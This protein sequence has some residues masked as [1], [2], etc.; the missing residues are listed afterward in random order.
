MTTYLKI[1]NPGVCPIE[2]FTLLG[3]TS[4]TG[5]N[6]AYCIGQFGSGTKLS[7]GV[8]IRAKLPPVVFCSKHKL[9]FST[10]R[11]V[12]KALEGNTHYDRIV[13]K[14]GGTDEHGTSVTYTEELSQ[15]ESYGVLDWDDIGM[16][17]REF[18]SNAIDATIKFNEINSIE[19]KYPFDGVKVEIVDESQVR[20]KQGFTRVFV[21]MTAEEMGDGIEAAVVNFKNNLGKWFLHFSEPELIGQAI[22]PKRNRNIKVDCRTAV[23][24]RRGVRVREINRQQGESLFDYN[25][26]KL[27]MD[28]SRNVDDYVAQGEASKA[29]AS[30]DKV[31][32]A[33]WF[34]S[35]QGKT[36]FWEHGFDSYNMQPQW[37][38][39]CESVEAK[40][41]NWAGAIEILGDNMVFVTQDTPCDALTRK[42]FTTLKVPESVARA[43][44]V[45]KL[46]TPEKV[47]GLDERAGREIIDPTDDAILALDFIWNEIKKAGM[48]KGKDCPPIKCF[49]SMM[50]AGCTISG[51]YREGVV[52]IN[53]NLA[54]GQ[55]VE[56]RQT[57]LEELAHFI[58]GSTD[59]TRDLQDWAF[60][61]A[62]RCMMVESGELVSG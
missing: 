35:F 53:E 34:R 20:A 6:S 59:C 49:R 60:Q 37:G 21:P 55:N 23:I 56:M 54:I 1:E 9:A 19:T 25:L 44:S 8:L 12:M 18:V 7:A 39:A 62:V 50:D 48:T 45:Y 29:L 24:Y 46:Q 14:H 52:F 40:E 41:K 57:L 51:F 17:L 31:H 5:S 58:T 22:L 13:V 47:L 43:A 28:E 38:E 15:T 32:L 61:F 27:R 4:K 36:S 33:T 26:N 11:G 42:G 2:G 16:A 3:A 10:K 30:A